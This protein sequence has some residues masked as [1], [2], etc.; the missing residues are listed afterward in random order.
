MCEKGARVTTKQMEEIRTKAF[1]R[2]A[3]DSR[4]CQVRADHLIGIL[5]AVVLELQEAGI[6]E[7]PLSTKPV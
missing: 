4:L 5:A 3:K 6:V 1:F 7:S 2:V